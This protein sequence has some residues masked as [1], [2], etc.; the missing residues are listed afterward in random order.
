[1]GPTDWSSLVAALQALG[2]K[3]AEVNQATGWVV[4]QVPTL[5]EER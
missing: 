1:M 3:V 2:L 5:E 4:V